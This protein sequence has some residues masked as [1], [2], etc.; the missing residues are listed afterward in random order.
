MCVTH[1]KM[2]NS[3]VILP[4]Y[5]DPIDNDFPDSSSEFAELQ[6]SPD[7]DNDAD[8]NNNGASVLFN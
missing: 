3:D 5:S 6:S 2:L 8:S 1:Y 7:S 4:N